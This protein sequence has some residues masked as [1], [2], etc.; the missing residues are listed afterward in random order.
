MPTIR[1]TRLAEPLSTTI[2]GRVSTEK[3]RTGQRDHAGG[4]QRCGDAEELRQ[5]LAEDHRE[6]GG[7]H[8]GQAADTA[9]TTAAPTAPAG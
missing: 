6:D 1:S 4:P 9:S 7:D 2:S 5:Q 3:T 8:Q